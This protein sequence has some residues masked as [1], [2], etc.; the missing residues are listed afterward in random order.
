MKHFA[1]L[2]LL[3]FLVSARA[4]AS[5][6]AVDIARKIMHTDKIETVHLTSAVELHNRTDGNGCVLIGYANGAPKVLGYSYSQA[7]D[8]NNLP[9]DFCSLLDNYT[10]KVHIPHLSTV[11]EHTTSHVSY[12]EIVKPLLGNISW[13]QI[14]PFNS[15]LPKI[16]NQSVTVGCVGLAFAM[17]M[18]Y[19]KWPEYGSG[20]LSYTW[21]RPDFTTEKISL[22]LGHNYEWNKIRDSYGQYDERTS[23]EIDA[24]ATLCRDIAYAAHTDFTTWNS[25]GS[26]YYACRHL[27]DNFDYDP[28][29]RRAAL[30]G[31]KQSDYINI[32]K[33]E[34]Q[35]GR[36]CLFASGNT[37]AGAGAHA[38]VCDGYDSN[39]F[40]HFNFGWGDAFTDMYYS[41]A[42]DG[43]LG[44]GQ[45]FYYGIKKYEGG[46]PG[47]SLSA[48]NDFAKGTDS[49]IDCQLYFWYFGPPRHI[50]I[51][52][53]VENITTK[54]IFY[55]ETTRTISED[56]TGAVPGYMKVTLNDMPKKDGDY[57][58]YPVGGFADEEWTKFT[59]G[60][61]YQD[62]F[63]LSIKNGIKTYSNPTINYPLE[64]DRVE[65][66]NVIYLL[67][68]ENLTATVTFRNRRFDHYDENVVIPPSV[69][70]NNNEYTVNKIGSQ[71]FFRLKPAFH[72]LSIPATIEEIEERACSGEGVTSGGSINEFN[73]PDGA[74]L[75]KIGKEAFSGC[76]FNSFKFPLGLKEIGDY[77]FIYNP[78]E[79]IDIPESVEYLGYRA[80]TT[81]GQ[82]SKVDVYVHWTSLS[83]KSINW[84]A[85]DESST[86]PAFRPYRTLHIPKGTIN[87]YQEA[88]AFFDAIIDDAEAGIDNVDINT[89]NTNDIVYTLQGIKVNTNAQLQPG[90]Y[91]LVSG[92]RARKIY[93]TGKP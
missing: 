32:L 8:Y 23:E 61:L 37:P 85:F 26:Q 13:E 83:D 35:A 48:F 71:A 59:F 87:I 60:D 92:D 25:G 15:K 27:I 11:N 47:I 6:T 39:D 10:Q 74:A 66:D 81:F 7:L 51:G 79:I 43:L 24:V 20:I 56:E 50:R 38:Y 5:E 80:F 19:H 46:E 90:V 64:G 73:I 16:D 2:L 9:S 77:A 12:R 17:L 14:D 82:A 41:I 22:S 72:S 45:A 44:E 53:A 67:D 88:S 76:E 68:D 36:P 78:L 63:C 54:E 18:N 75:K 65:I 33:T 62:Y 91:I 86:T 3:T 58:V 84:H 29:I 69:E 93:L 30:D 34:L 42:H 28:G 40:F 4:F 31:M 52:Y 57:I 21:W 70:F 89:D 1:L 55:Y 49:T